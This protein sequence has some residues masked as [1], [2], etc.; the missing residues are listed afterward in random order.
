M[1]A[2]SAQALGQ[3][4]SAWRG[5]QQ[6]SLS[7]AARRLSVHA[8]T[9][10]RWEE[11]RRPYA[12]HLEAIADALGADLATV[13]AL[14]GPAPRRPRRPAPADAPVLVRAR[15]EAG[16]DRVELGRALHVGPATVY[17]WERGNT[18]PP[19]DLLPRLA[20][21]L[22]LGREELDLALADHPPCR[23]DGEVLP[24]L[25]AVLRER[26]WTRAQVRDLLEVASSTVFAWETGR[27]RVPSW[28]LRRL[29]TACGTEV[30]ELTACGRRRVGRP[31]SGLAALR[32]QIRMTQREAAAVL[33]VSASSLGRYETG[34]RPIALP[35]ARGMARV[36]RVPLARVLAAA[37][38]APPL[39]LTQ[40]WTEAQLPAILADLRQAAGASMSEVARHTGVSHPTVRRWESGESL[41]SAGALA[42]LELQYRLGRGR[43]T[44]LARSGQ[45]RAG[46]RS[47]SPM[48][49][50]AGSS[51]PV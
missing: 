26:G 41:P 36:Y 21:Q 29:A 20:R 27:T 19:E 4:L 35:L 44:A 10:Q 38:L 43:L 11:G 7:A 42:T 23:Y 45:E 3:R 32:R 37:G 12:R 16:L 46:S 33:G 1:T 25:G 39:L 9:F 22:G 6:M 15:L 5:G 31:T 24:G 30:E 49:S 2:P 13:T 40:P 17:Q 18:R 50:A 8:T 51:S 28:A 48:G 14:A 47:R 34:R